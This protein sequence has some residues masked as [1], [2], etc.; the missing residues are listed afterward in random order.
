MQF[1][2]VGYVNL[3]PSLLP[4]SPPFAD[5]SDSRLTMS[6]DFSVR[7]NADLVRARMPVKCVNLCDQ[8]DWNNT[9]LLRPITGS[10]SRT[11]TR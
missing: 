8:L 9:A 10:S 3:A 4:I 2:V 6:E 7:S 11:S 1:C 5:F